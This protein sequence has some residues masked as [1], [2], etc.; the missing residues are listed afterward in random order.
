[1]IIFVTL[2]ER[3]ENIRS[4][5]TLGKYILSEKLYK[6]MTLKKL[7]IFRGTVNHSLQVLSFPLEVA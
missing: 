7:W 4:D 3:K 6:M 2:L 5:Y 1:M